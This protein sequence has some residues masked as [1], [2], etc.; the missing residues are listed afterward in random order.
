MKRDI[1]LHVIAL[2]LVVIAELIGSISF[3]VGPGTVVLLPMLFALIMGMLLGPK[4]LKIVDMEDM[5]RAAPWINISVM[6]LIAKYG[7]NIGPT[8][9]LLIKSSPALLLQEFGNLGTIFLSLPI[10]MLLGLKRETIGATFSIAREGSLAIISDVYGLDS[11][12]GRGVMGVYICGTLF[13]TIF[14]GIMAGLLAPIFH[15]FAL[16]MACGVGSASMMAASSGSLVAIFPQY[17][18]EIQAF[19]S[20]SNLLTGADGVYMSIFMALPITEWLYKRFSR[21]RSSVKAEVE[22]DE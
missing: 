19:A 9:P 14:F 8:M 20:A 5:K 1:K 2:I 6:L 7:T 21:G 10:A 22:A 4:V 3:K 11:P 12:E 13:G 15:P 16:A 17:A 18:A